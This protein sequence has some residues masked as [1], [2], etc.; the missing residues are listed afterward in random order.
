V[1][2][3]HLADLRSERE[4]L[5]DELDQLPVEHVDLFGESGRVPC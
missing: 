1:L 4:T 5:V 2:R 3:L